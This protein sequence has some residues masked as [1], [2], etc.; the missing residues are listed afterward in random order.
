MKS[1]CKA[2]TFFVTIAQQFKNLQHMHKLPTVSCLVVPMTA[3]ALGG[4]MKRIERLES[5]DSGG[6]DVRHTSFCFASMRDKSLFFTVKS[7]GSSGV[8]LVV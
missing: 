2:T 1:I 4:K 8:A 3:V 7:T 6:E 5:R